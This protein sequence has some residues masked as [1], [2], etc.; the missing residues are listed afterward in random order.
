VITFEVLLLN[1][2]GWLEKLILVEGLEELLVVEWVN[3]PL[4]VLLVDE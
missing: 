1:V 4:A 3:D 2:I